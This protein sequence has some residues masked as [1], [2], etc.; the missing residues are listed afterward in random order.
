[1][2][3]VTKNKILKLSKAA[4]IMIVGLFFF[5]FI[6]MEICGKDI[7]FDAS[8]HITVTIFILYFLWFYVDQNKSW[9]VPYFIFG[10]V[11]IAIVS[12]QRILVH[13]HDDVGLLTG[14]IISFISIMFSQKDYFKDKLKF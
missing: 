10:L 1:M 11:V 2:K 7:L 3:R 13:A 14:L 5:K 9:R 8:A 6:P 4:L 12:I